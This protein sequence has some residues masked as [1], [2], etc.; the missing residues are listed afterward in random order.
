LEYLLTDPNGIY[1]DGTLGTG[2]HARNIL[3]S[4]LP[5][6]RLIGLDI[7]EEAL[8]VARHQLKPFKNQFAIHHWNYARLPELF[9]RESLV[10]VHGILLDLGISS[11]QLDMTERGFSYLSDGPLDM[12]MSK[13]A[14]VTAQEII[15]TY[16]EDS[17]AHLFLNLGEER[18]AKQIAHIIVKCR[19][20]RRITTTAQ[21]YGLISDNTSSRKIIATCARIF[22]A[23]RIEV[24][25][26]LANLE[27]FLDKVITCLRPQGRLVIISYHSLEDRLVK[28]AFRK[29]S[30][31]KDPI[32][33]SVKSGTGRW[34]VLTKRPVRPSQNEI[35]DNPR[36]RSAKLRSAEFNE[37]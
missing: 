16:S 5:S 36:A 7:D 19:A 29:G 17:L 27:Q 13:G 28:Q 4:L 23:L 35:K 34:R 37:E 32:T 8:E 2:G 25:Q 10:P 26:E 1:V 3:S 20:D 21:L 9:L 31:K 15:N 22:Q 24:N 33:G 18:Q 11:F 12:R 14:R 6:G 30:P